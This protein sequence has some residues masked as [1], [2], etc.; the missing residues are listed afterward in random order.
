[1]PKLDLK[2]DHKALFTASARVVALVDV[3]RLSYLMVDGEGDPSGNASFAEAIELLYSTSYTLKFAAKK[4]DT[5]RDWA[6]MPLE[7]LW[8]VQKPRWWWTLMIAQPDFVTAAEVRKAAGELAR[9][10]DR[11][12]YAR[13]RLQKFAEGRSVQTLHVGPYDAETP[14]IERMRQFAREQGLEFAGKH[15]EIYLS[16]PRR[17]APEKL[18]TILRQPV[19]KRA[20]GSRA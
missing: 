6:V 18:K 2:K 17:V 16:D 12:S 13:L 20:G 1:V 3:P 15:H 4:A 14:T 10:H 8:V 7:G 11:R 5:G 19:K 9:K